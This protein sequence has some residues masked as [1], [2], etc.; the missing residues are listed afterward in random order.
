MEPHLDC[1][2]STGAGRRNR[3]LAVDGAART[4]EETSPMSIG[5][6]WA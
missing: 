2:P 1:L 4:R 3:V 6:A 5:A